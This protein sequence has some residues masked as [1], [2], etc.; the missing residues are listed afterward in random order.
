MEAIRLRSRFEKRF[1]IGLILSETTDRA[2]Q[3]AG[4]RAAFKSPAREGQDVRRLQCAGSSCRR[5]RRMRERGRLA[6]GTGG[7]GLFSDMLEDLRDL[8]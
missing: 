3:R 4:L 8:R 1:R 5:C 6:S 7:R 2:A